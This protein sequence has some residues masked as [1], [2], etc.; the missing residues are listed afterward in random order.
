MRGNV[1]KV[2]WP[3]LAREYQIKELTNGTRIKIKI[4]VV[5]WW[6]IITKQMDEEMNNSAATEKC[7]KNRHKSNMNERTIKGNKRKKCS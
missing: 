5:K 7:K 6:M 2:G 4:R 3:S 1:G